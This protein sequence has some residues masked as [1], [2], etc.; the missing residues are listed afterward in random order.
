MT[1]QLDWE[2]LSDDGMLEASPKK[3]CI[4]TIFKLSEG[5]Y[6]GKVAWLGSEIKEFKEHIIF[7]GNL[8]DCMKACDEFYEESNSPVI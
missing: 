4:Y 6:T 8:R 1:N 2:M 5:N 3:N 7:K